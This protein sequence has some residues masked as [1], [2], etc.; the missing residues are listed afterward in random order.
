MDLKL[1]NS[2]FWN[3]IE[4]DVDENEV[5]AI[6]S[7]ITNLKMFSSLESINLNNWD[8]MKFWDYDGTKLVHKSRIYF[9]V[10]GV[11]AEIIGREVSVWDQPILRQLEHGISALIIAEKNDNL[12]CLIQAKSECGSFD[13]LELAPTVQCILGSYRNP[14][15]EIPYLDFILNAHEN[16]IVSNTLQSEEGGRF[17]K[18]QNRNYVVFSSDLLSIESANYRWCRIKD[19][20]SL[21]KYNNLLNIELRTLFSIF[22]PI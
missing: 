2:L 5:V 3:D 21:I 6:L 14:E 19:L 13:N 10:L 17:Y 7:W 16:Y 1:L 20:R 4:S 8:D 9:E 22:M 18:E 11:R 12:Y 15:S